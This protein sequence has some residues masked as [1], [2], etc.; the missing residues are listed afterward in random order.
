MPIGALM[1][2]V[3]GMP[4]GA[5]LQLAADRLREEGSDLLPVLDDGRLVGVV[6]Q[7]SL[8]RCLAEGK[9]ASESIECATIEA[10]ALISPYAPGAEALRA[11]SQTGGTSVV[12][13]DPEGRVL[14]TLSPADLF[15]R[16]PERPRPPI[17]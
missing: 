12:V 16:V 15:P 3:E 9:S 8:G 1:R 13:V 17:V 6:T 14:G 5:S 2:P 10:P 11:F 4:L 7:L